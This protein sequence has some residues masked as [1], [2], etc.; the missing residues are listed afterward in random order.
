MYSS[1]GMVQAAQTA[2]TAQTVQADWDCPVQCE[3]VYYSV[4]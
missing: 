3:A 1:T 2:Q 4:M